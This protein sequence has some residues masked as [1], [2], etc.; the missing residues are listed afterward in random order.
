MAGKEGQGYARCLSQQHWGV[1]GNQTLGEMGGW[2][3]NNT[4]TGLQKLVPNGKTAFDLL[5]VRS[6]TDGF[7]LEF[8]QPV[9]DGGALPKYMVEQW[10]YVPTSAYGGPEVDKATLTVQSATVS[11]DAKRVRLKLSGLKTGYVVHIKVTGLKSLSAENLWASDAWYTLNNLGP[12]VV[13]TRLRSKAGPNS[14]SVSEKIQIVS[15]SNGKIRFA[16]ST[17]GPFSLKI[18]DA[19]GK[20]QGKIQGN[21]A[22]SYYWTCPTGHLGLY[23]YQLTRLGQG[24]QIGHL[25]LM[26]MDLN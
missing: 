6:Q 1:R 18:H 7:E 24:T 17:E 3:W 4:W 2:N 26:G 20:L 11:S 25:P 9:V 19:S 5:A 10:R 15:A 13:T 12:A 16:I 8:T 22:G 21:S 14:N 23:T